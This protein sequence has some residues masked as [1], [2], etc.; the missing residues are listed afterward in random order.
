M[1]ERAVRLAQVLNSLTTP[2][3]SQRDH[4]NPAQETSRI[5]RG[6]GNRSRHHDTGSTPLHSPGVLTP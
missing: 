3:S 1:N 6:P 2:R 4:M 5:L